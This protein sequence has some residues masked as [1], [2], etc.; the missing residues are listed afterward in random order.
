[1]STVSF[2]VRR[3]LCSARPVAIQTSANPSAS[4]QDLQQVLFLPFCFMVL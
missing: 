2:Q 3:L 1:M 4:D